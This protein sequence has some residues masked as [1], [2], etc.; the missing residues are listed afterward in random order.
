M[1]TFCDQN[2]TFKITFLNKNH[3]QSHLWRSQKHDEMGHFNINP[4]GDLKGGGY[5]NQSTHPS[6]AGDDEDEDE[7]E[8]EDDDDD[9]DA[10]DDDNEN[11]RPS[12][13]TQIPSVFL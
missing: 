5:M 11:V 12:K 9:D 6:H 13:L 10:D 2:L 4:W 1:L 7:D 8:D 3:R